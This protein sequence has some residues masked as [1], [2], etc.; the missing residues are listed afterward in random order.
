MN[1]LIFAYN[2]PELEKKIVL[3]EAENLYKSNVVSE[4]QWQK[5]QTVFATKLYTP[6]IFMKILLFIV[7]LIGMLTIIG[8]IGLIFGDIGESGYRF[9]TF[10]LG[11]SLL[12]LTDQLLIKDKLHYKSG[13]TEAGIYSGLLFIAFAL[14]GSKSHSTII[15]PIV[16]FLLAAFAAIRY[17]NLT[18][19]VVTIGFFGWI[20]FQ[21]FTDIGGVA[22]ALLPFIFMVSF[23]SIYWGSNK[24]EL[25]VSKEFLHNHFLII[26]TIS[27]V[28]IYLAGNYFV[29]RELSIRLLGLTLAEKQDIPFAFVFYGFTAI[30]PLAYIFWGLRQKLILFIRVGLLTLALS[31]ITLKYYFSLGMPIV[32]IT[33]TGAMLIICALIF[34]NYLKRF[35]HGYTREKLLNDK[36]S[37]PNLMAFIASQTLVGNQI[38]SSE[39]ENPLAGGG[40]F[41]GGGAGGNW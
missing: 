35:R 24:L 29:V 21:I 28:L 33:V 39:S 5:I 3:S 9:L 41:G 17:L 1:N 16:G 22:Q 12:F 34:L 14:L 25:K 15:Y 8:P 36:W 19:L 2:L 18:A 7:S 13:V 38:C 6:T 31:V 11:F 32:T 27:L 30:I 4:E 26:Q 20:L 40:S 10:I 23:S 37:S